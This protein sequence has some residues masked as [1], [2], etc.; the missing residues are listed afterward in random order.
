M[1]NL[2][3]LLAGL[4]FGVGLIVSGM[5]DPAKVL[6]FLDITRVWDPS[7]VFVMGG[8]VMTGLLIFQLVMRR[9]RALLVD[10]L[11]LPAARDV[12]KRLVGGAVLFGI[13]WGL[14]GIC[15]GPA[16][17]LLS[18]GSKKGALFFIAMLVGMGLF[19]YLEHR[20]GKV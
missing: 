1:Y 13:G 19:D 14:S 5:S 3:S 7:L 11:F 4:L 12:N 16:L 8:A 17:I 9:G 2:V 6:G 10:K 20:P 15:P 18:S